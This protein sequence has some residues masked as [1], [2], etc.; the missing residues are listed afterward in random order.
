MLKP[1]LATGLG[2]YL[3]CIMFEIKLEILNYFLQNSTVSYSVSQTTSD[4]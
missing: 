3:S 4:L 2:R 1:A